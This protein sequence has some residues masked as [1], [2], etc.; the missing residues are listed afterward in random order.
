MQTINKIYG[1]SKTKFVIFYYKVPTA[2]LTLPK[3]M[4]LI[5][6][7]FVPKLFI[8]G[9]PKSHHHG[10]KNNKNSKFKI[11]MFHDQS[12]SKCLVHPNHVLIL[13][14]TLPPLCFGFHH[15]NPWKMINCE[16]NVFC[17]F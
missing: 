17:K 12:L 5:L 6:P 4:C 10:S 1:I 3:T 15:R 8:L 11:T 2:P 14:L 13:P 7:S 16:M 9:S